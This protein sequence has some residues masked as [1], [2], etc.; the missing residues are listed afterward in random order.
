MSAQSGGGSGSGSGVAN[1]DGNVKEAL[2]SL[3]GDGAENGKLP[4]QQS[5]SSLRGWSTYSDVRICDWEG[6][7]CRPRDKDNNSNS[8]GARDDVIVGINITRGGLSGGSLSSHLGLLSELEH[9]VLPNNMLRGSIPQEVANLPKLRTLDLTRCFLS[10]TLPQRFQ[11]K[12]LSKLLLAH[13]A[14]TGR[15]FEDE[16]SPHLESLKE[17]R[18]E[19]NLLTGT[20]VGRTLSKMTNLNVLSLSDNDLSGLLPGESL[21]DLPNLHYLYL[22]SNS[23]VGALPASLARVGGLSLREIWVQ[24]NMLSGTVPV[25][26]ARFTDLHDFFID[27]NKLSG[28]LPLELCSPN[29]NADFFKKHTD[30]DG[31][32]YCENIACPTGSVSAEGLYP[33]TK[34][35]GGEAAMLKNRYL[36]MKGECSDHT[37]RTI[38]EAFYRSTTKGGRWSGVNDW[39]DS[40]KHVCDMTGITCDAQRHV[41][42]IALSDRKLQGHLPDEIGLLPF[43]E[44]LDVSDNALMGYVPSDLRWTSLTHLDVSG[45]KFRGLIPPLLC[46]MEGLNG[47]GYHC[48]RLACPRGTFNSAGYHQGGMDGE[49]CQPCYDDSLYIGQKVCS[50]IKPPNQ[51]QVEGPISSEADWEEIIEAVEEVEENE[52]AIQQTASEGKHKGVSSQAAVEIAVGALVLVVAI[53]W[54]VKRVCCSPNRRKKSRFDYRGDDEENKHTYFSRNY[55]DRHLC[56]DGSYT[57]ERSFRDGGGYRDDP[58][59]KD[60]RRMGRMSEDR[61]TADDYSFRPHFQDNSRYQA[62]VYRDFEDN[63]NKHHVSPLE[64]SSVDSEE[65]SQTLRSATDFIKDHQGIALTKR[66]KFRRAVSKRLPAG[67]N[68]NQRAQRTASNLNVGARRRYHAH[69]SRTASFDS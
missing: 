22:D 35:P 48:D 17:I 66:E 54:V 52:S 26:F 57:V 11:S 24:K 6:V 56:D 58:Q 46:K 64:E 37:Q 25:A 67:Q 7:A 60:G 59:G 18:M 13:N 49:D 29:V 45:N 14:I 47:V 30:D 21:G 41:V 9:L 34:C 8:S 63:I 51:S 3:V 50:N 32:N 69:V 40:T 15:F 44:T 1:L 12:Y 65:D 16:D 43:L 27:S 61:A 38:L 31:R 53:S 42:G 23:L 5:S 19:N 68:L 62:S 10:G 33:C 39:T 36:G 28:A 20:L 4:T 2:L 55:D